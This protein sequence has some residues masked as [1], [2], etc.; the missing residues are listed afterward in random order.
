MRAEIVL[1]R[2]RNDFRAAVNTLIAAGIS[3]RDAFLA[4]AD[5]VGDLRTE[6]MKE[7]RRCY[8]QKH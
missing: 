7:W 5:A 3:E 1:D 2:L 6:V 8:E 4:A